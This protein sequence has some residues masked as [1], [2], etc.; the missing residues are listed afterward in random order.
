MSRDGKALE[1]DEYRILGGDGKW[2][3]LRREAEL[4]PGKNGARNTILITLQDVTERVHMEDELRQGYAS[5]K[6][7][8]RMG[9]IGSVDV[10]LTTMKVSWSEELYEIY[11]RDP[12]EGP[13]DLETFLTFLHPDDRHMIPQIRAQYARPAGGSN[14]FR[15]VRPDGSVR[16]IHREA[17][18]IR[19]SQ[20]RPIGLITVE[21]D[22]TDRVT[23]EDA[24]RRG[25]DRL[26]M[27]QRIGK[28]GS[29]EINLRTRAA[30]RSDEFNRLM[31]FDAGPSAD[32]PDAVVDAIHPDDRETVREVMRRT[33][34]GEVVPPV[35]LRVLH[36][37]GSIAWVRRHHDFIR[38]AAAFRKRRS[39]SFRTSPNR[40]GWSRP[41]TNSSR[42]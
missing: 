29:A 32:G 17:E 7:A 2:R 10:D 40:S 18:Q 9:R 23:M 33:S 11:G 25:H 41:R 3:W 38:N 15:I 8:Q 34:A 13:A 37:D 21:Q 24:L 28:V 20:G 12:K 4:L 27:A 16:W 6:R 31:G 26:A 22:V 5:L 1:P 39:S 36:E 35:D 19:D 14:E 30:F 42:P